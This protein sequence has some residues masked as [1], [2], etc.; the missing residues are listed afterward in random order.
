MNTIFNTKIELREIK[1][2]YKNA[3]NVNNLF[4]KNELKVK[5]LRRLKTMKANDKLQEYRIEQ[6]TDRIMRM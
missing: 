5:L 2:I 3:L 4:Y 1:K 6:M